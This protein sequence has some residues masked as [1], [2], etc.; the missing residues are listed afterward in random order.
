MHK[1]E[2]KALLQQ[3]FTQFE[4]SVD[5]VGNLTLLTI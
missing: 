2:I 5:Y 3:L 4:L 1:K